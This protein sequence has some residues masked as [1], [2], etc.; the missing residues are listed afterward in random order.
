MSEECWPCA[1]L[2]EAVNDEKSG[3]GEKV[4]VSV[5]VLRLPLSGTGVPVG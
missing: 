2:G 1:G 5:V 4:G 3:A